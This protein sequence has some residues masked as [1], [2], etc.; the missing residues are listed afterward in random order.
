MQ[1]VLLV[2]TALAAVANWSSRVRD[3]QRMEQWSKPL[4]TG[5]V[6]GLALV[7]GAPHDRITIA[8]LALVLCLVGDVALMAPIDNFVAGLA[9]FLLGHVVFVVLFVK[10]G[11]HHPRLAGVALILAALLAASAGRVIVLGAARHDAKLRVPVLAYLGV[12]STMATFGWA[13]GSGWVVVGCTLF[14]I[15][16]AVLGWRQFVRERP[17][18]GLTV[19][20]TYHLAIGALAISLW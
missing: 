12:I 4:T 19:M 6:I 13:T 8:V 20:V 11:L 7:S 17:W 14:V 9:A 16:D 5:L 10:M 18:M 15:S 3:D 2:A 1:I